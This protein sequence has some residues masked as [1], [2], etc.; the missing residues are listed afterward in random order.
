M[1]MSNLGKSRR[2]NSAQ[3]VKTLT[4]DEDLLLAAAADGNAT[5]VVR[6]VI[7]NGVK[8]TTTLLSPFGETAVLLAVRANSLE[9]LQA[10]LKHCDESVVNLPDSNKNYPIVLAISSN[11]NK[12]GTRII[13]S[14]DSDVSR[15][16]FQ[17]IK[18]KPEQKQDVQKIALNVLAR[19]KMTY[20][21]LAA[22]ADPLPAV[23]SVTNVQEGID[24]EAL[25]FLA[26][27]ETICATPV[28]MIVAFQFS[29]ALRKIAK[30]QLERS[31]EYTNLANSCETLAADLLHESRDLYDVRK[32]LNGKNN[33]LD[34]AVTLNQKS[35]ISHPYAQQYLNEKWLG[36]YFGQQSGEIARNVIF[37]LSIFPF[38]MPFR[39]IWFL[40]FEIKGNLRYTRLGETFNLYN[41]PIVKYFGS[42]ICFVGFVI[43]LLY[44]AALKSESIPNTVE[45]ILA[46]WIVGM[47]I[48]EIREAWRATRYFNDPWNQLD[49]LMHTMFVTIIALRIVVWQA[50]DIVSEERVLF[51][52]NVLTG[53]VTA[54][55]CIRL[56]NLAQVNQT[57]GPL[58]LIVAE[59]LTDLTVFIT[60]FFLFVLS[61]AA[62]LTKVYQ[63]DSGDD[64]DAHILSSFPRAMESLF[65][66]LFGLTELSTFDTTNEDDTIR[67]STEVIGKLLLGVYM[68]LVS[69]LM[70]NLLIAMMNATYQR[71]HDNA[72]TEWKFLRSRLIRS[73]QLATGMP[74]PFNLLLLPFFVFLQCL[75]LKPKKIHDNFESIDQD[76]RQ[77]RN[78]HRVLVRRYEEAHIVKDD[79]HVL[80]K[81]ESLQKQ[82]DEMQSMLQQL[83]H[84]AKPPENNT[85]QMGNKEVIK[86]AHIEVD[87]KE[88]VDTVRR[89]SSSSSEKVLGWGSLFQD[90]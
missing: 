87:G 29:D 76:K 74:A 28:P 8:I 6:L 58:Q 63:L 41:T 37:D 22:E 5:E 38:R 17:N 27:P 36:D 39:I 49:L 53:I 13:Q 66:I 23:H 30:K 80:D 85:Q 84:L 10:V 18:L 35:F 61:F 72:D 89:I 47:L 48:D 50:T 43:L 59:I 67:I 14:K 64:A 88:R 82:T 34:M 75:G 19:K 15:L 21:L 65:W 70:I 16:N 4:E 79:A 54:L 20:A 81:L 44:N 9:C 24:L 90:S 52:A 83:V 25:R 68:M 1:E 86:A 57:L 55:C 60:F 12:H 26:E 33:I 45:I 77:M 3:S 69:V 78:L 46:I 32:L 40:L 7:E 51:S 42:A 11:I 73:Q 2:V 71:I 31:I 56:L 62:A